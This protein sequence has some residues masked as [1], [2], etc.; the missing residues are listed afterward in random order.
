VRALATLGIDWS[1]KFPKGLDAVDSLDWDFIISTC[2]PVCES[3]PALSNQPTY[4]RWGVPDPAAAP[5]GL[6]PDD[7]FVKTAHLLLWR[8]DLMLAIRPDVLERTASTQT[9]RVPRREVRFR[10]ESAA[11]AAR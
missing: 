6:Q 10:A 7:P 5:A 8:I 2:D 1:G 11:S 3:A 4:A 9:A